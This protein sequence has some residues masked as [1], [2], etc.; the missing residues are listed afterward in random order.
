MQSKA[1]AFFER[2][3]DEILTRS[4]ISEK[5]GCRHET[6]CLV[7][8]A[9]IRNR[10]V[11]RDQLPRDD[12]NARRVCRVAKTF[13][14]NLAPSLRNAIEAFIKHHNIK[15]AAAASGLSYRTFEGYV[16]KARAAAGVKTTNA[17][18]DAYTV[19]IQEAARAHA[20]L[21]TQLSEVTT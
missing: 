11:R 18:A 10:I 20:L 6:A 1:V 13:P 12:R 8:K 2:N 15:A 19:A 14:D 7:A 9:L 17:L 21:P 4:D 16:K 3:P 5:F